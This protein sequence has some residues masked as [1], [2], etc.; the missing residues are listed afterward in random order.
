[1]KDTPIE[2]G[3]ASELLEIHLEDFLEYVIAYGEANGYQWNN[4]MV[5]ALTSFVYNLGKSRLKQLTLSLIH[6]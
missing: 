5:G 2:E 6:I 3:R 4:N 1:M